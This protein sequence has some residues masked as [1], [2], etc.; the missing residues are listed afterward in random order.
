MPKKK[1]RATT[2]KPSQSSKPSNLNYYY[3]Q[4]GLLIR[5]HRELKNLTQLT[6]SNQLGFNNSMFISLVER[7]KTKVPL[8]TIGKLVVLLSI[9]EA[10]ILNLSVSAYQYDLE[11]GVKNGMHQA[12]HLKK[13]ID[14]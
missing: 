8:T 9:P 12:L 11:L 1:V 4:I 7:G 14:F 5:K 13:A 2:E 6:L 10:E 3:H